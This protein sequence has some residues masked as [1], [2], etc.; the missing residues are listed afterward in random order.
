MRQRSKW[1]EDKGWGED[2]VLDGAGCMHSA[3]C[4]TFGEC[5]HHFEKVKK[6]A[7]KMACQ[8]ETRLCPLG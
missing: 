1:R 3:W 2:G 5:G 8:V 7:P 6:V 4:L